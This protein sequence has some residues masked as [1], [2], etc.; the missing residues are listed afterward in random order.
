MFT[1]KKRARDT[2]EDGYEECARVIKVYTHRILPPWEPFTKTQE[3][4]CR[5]PFRTSPTSKH[6]RGFSQSLRSKPSPLF[7]QT[8]T[9]ADSS[10]EETS[11]PLTLS[12]QARQQ[13]STQV[14]VSPP[15]LILE[16]TLDSDMDVTDSRP[17]VSPRYLGQPTAI[18]SPNAS[19]C[20][21]VPPLPAFRDPFKDL[22]TSP[23]GGRLPTPIYGH[24]Q[25]GIDA[26]MDMSE[27]SEDIIPRSQQ[28][29]EYENHARRRRLPTPIDE[30]EVM[31]SSITMGRLQMDTE[32]YY[33]HPIAKTNGFSLQ[34]R[35]TRLS[36]S[37]GIRADCELCRMKVPGHSNHI[38]KA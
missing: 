1:S 23:S 37:M 20:T 21:V 8:I 6:N 17:L 16:Q 36:F 7:T 22:Q 25:Q 29:I 38:F 11:P 10:E 28:E 12:I 3:Q 30:D 2:E 35:T 33:G 18:S 32:H 26:M 27:D 24:F 19:P 13:P 34:A 9:P 14:S 31:D 4:Q 15:P 5:L